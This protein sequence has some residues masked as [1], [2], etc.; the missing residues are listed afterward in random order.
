MSFEESS[1]QADYPAEEMFNAQQYAKLQLLKGRIEKGQIP[2]RKRKH[3]D[4]DGHLPGLNRK[5]I[6]RLKNVRDFAWD[7]KDGTS[8]GY[9]RL[10]APTP[11]HAQNID[12]APVSDEIHR[13]IRKLKH[14]IQRRSD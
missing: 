5:N 12:H 4:E 8:I 13:G 1:E 6:R 7:I 14:W 9:A 2:N 11:E 10:H 3:T